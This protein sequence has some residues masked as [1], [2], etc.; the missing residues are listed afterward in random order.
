MHRR[1]NRLHLAVIGLLLPV[2]FAQETAPACR[3]PNLPAEVRAADLVKRMTLEEKV[4]QLAGGRRRAMATASPEAKEVFDGLAKLYQ[5][6]SQVS[7]HDAAEARNKVQHFLVEKTRLGIPTIFQGEALHGFM[8]Y[9]STS[10]PQALG[11]ASTWNPDLV[12][13]NGSRGH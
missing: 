10:F 13:K 4:N 2:C 6:D 3:N 1:Q 7:P 11:L 9:G 8:A 12:R 5:L